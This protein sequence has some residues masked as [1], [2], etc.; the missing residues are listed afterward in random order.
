[1]IYI[2][3]PVILEKKNKVLMYSTISDSVYN[4]GVNSDKEKIFYLTDE[5]YGKYLTSETSDCF[6]IGILIMALKSGQDIDCDTIS[7][8][9]YYNLYH[10]VIPLISEI[11]GFNPIKIHYKHLSNQIFNAKA[12][13][14]GCS[15]GVDSFS[16]IADHISEECPSSFRLTHLTYFNVGAH[17][18]K[19][20]NKV[21][22][23]YE[24]DYKLVAA[25]AKYKKMPVVKIESNLANFYEGFDFDQCA[26]L[27]NMSV[28]LSM[29]K[30]FKRYVYAS[31]FHIKDTHFT[32]KDMHYQSPFLL[33]ALSTETTEL[34]NGDPCLNR[35]DKTIKIANFNDTYQYL[36]VCWKELIVNNDLNADIA[37]VKDKFLNCTRCDKCMRT[38]LTLDIIGKIDFYDKIFDLDHYRKEKDFYIGKV[39]A[40]IKQDAF[41]NDIY[42]LM[43]RYKYKISYKSWL[44]SILWK[45]YRNMGLSV[46]YGWLRRIVGK[47]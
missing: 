28:V 23:S 25:Y 22:Q 27:R 38:V 19:D 39:I 32:S 2:G 46:N 24:N 45:I 42:T 14:S 9:L 31:S 20:F 21:K 6:I 43:K 1:M 44:Y 33:P 13:G 30:L 15:L 11:Y 34:I 5:E 12:V 41:Y 10:T 37:K 47:K 16:T 17:G 7:E 36:Y 8:K 18:D 29:Q 35:S 40:N 3:K 4:W 26:L